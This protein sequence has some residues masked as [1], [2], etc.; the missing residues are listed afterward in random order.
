MHEQA[1][2]KL[3]STESKLAYLSDQKDNHKHLFYS[4]S[5]SY[6][7]GESFESLS[8]ELYVGHKEDYEYSVFLRDYPWPIHSPCQ[9]CL[10]YADSI[11]STEVRS[12]IMVP[13]I[14]HKTA[15]GDEALL[16]ELWGVW[17]PPFVIITTRST[18]VVPVRVHLWV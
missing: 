5:T 11:L 10:E 14:W 2:H 18:L 15:F 13:L 4:R 8:G 1:H 16:L 17:G 7:S 12:L 3:H 9:H 6:L